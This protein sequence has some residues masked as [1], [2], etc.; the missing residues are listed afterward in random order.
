VD[1]V[2]PEQRSAGAA[3]KARAD[4]AACLGILDA[5]LGG[6][7]FLLGGYSLADTHLQGFVGWLGMMGVDLGP[8]PNVAGWMQRCGE[9]PAL[10]RLLWRV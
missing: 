6:R 10:A 8:F 1:W 7:P 5:A 3:E 2:P 4:L 9:R